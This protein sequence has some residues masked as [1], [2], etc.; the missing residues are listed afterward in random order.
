MRLG[1]AV[2][3]PLRRRDG[4]TSPSGLDHVVELA[5]TSE[6]SGFDALL[7]DG[8]PAVLTPASGAGAGASRVDPFVVLGAVAVSTSTLALGCL[9]THLDERPPALLAKAVS[10]LDACSDGRA[11][12]ALRPSDDLASDGGIERL[13]EALEVCR[14]LLRVRAPSF[15]GRFYRLERAFNEPR[16]PRSGGGVPVALEVPAATSGGQL[17]GLVAVA[18]RFAELCVLELGTGSDPVARLASLL[19]VLAPEARRAG[20]ANGGPFVIARLV[21]A[22]LDP[23]RIAED[24]EALLAAGAGGVVVDWSASGVSRDEVATVGK[25][26]AA[27][28][29]R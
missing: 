11:L 29:P 17:V 15:T 26:V 20:R 18:A 8:T 10:A 5:R 19:D 3:A 9:A 28:Q 6:D 21:A 14:A 12:L 25:L 24:A 27:A 4:D 1:V 22:G 7:L 13:A 2:R 23:A 16:L